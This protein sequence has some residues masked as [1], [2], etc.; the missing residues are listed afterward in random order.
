MSDKRVVIWPTYLDKR[1]SR[2]EG[3]RVPRRLSVK[4]PKLDEIRKALEKLGFEP[5]I[6]SD[7]AYPRRWWEGGG[8]I[9]VQNVNSK[10]E[11]LR[12]VAMKIKEMRS[13]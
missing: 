1:A 11:L 2:K 4:S 6:E 3:R 12:A 7:K 5:E 8:R 10:G 9:T 13:Q